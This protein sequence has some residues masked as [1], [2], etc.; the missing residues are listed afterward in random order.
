MMDAV[1]KMFNHDDL[2]FGIYP[3][4]WNLLGTNILPFLSNIFLKF[5]DRYLYSKGWNSTGK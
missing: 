5:Q 1:R 4:L 3:N 2:I